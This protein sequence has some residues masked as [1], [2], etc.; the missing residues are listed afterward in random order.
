[1]KRAEEKEAEEENE[2]KAEAVSKR[3]TRRQAG[4]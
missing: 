4:E 1:M 3:G 2:E